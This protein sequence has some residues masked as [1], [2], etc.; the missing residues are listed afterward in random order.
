MISMLSC[1]HSSGMLGEDSAAEDVDM[2]DAE[3]QVMLP[4]KSN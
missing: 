2:A 3:Q 1:R 4:F